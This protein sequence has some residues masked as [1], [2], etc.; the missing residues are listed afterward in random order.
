MDANI[1][2]QAVA[3]LLMKKDRSRLIAA[4]M[5]RLRCDLSIENAQLVNVLTG[6]IYPASVDVLDGVTVRVR[7]PDEAAAL[8]AAQ[9]ID[10]GGRY[11]LPGLIDS[12]MHVESSLLV[13]ENFGKAAVVWGTTMVVTDPHEIANVLGADG[14]RYMLDSARRSPVRQFALVPSCVPSLPGLETSGAVLTPEIIGA[15]LDEDGVIGLAEVMDYGAV[16]ADDPRMHGVLAAADARGCFIQGHAPR[17]MGQALCG[18]LVAGPVSDH[19]SKGAD[20]VLDKRRSGMYVDLRAH[21]RA[22]AAEV[23]AGLREGRFLDRVTLCTDDNHA[24]RLVREGHINRT[25][26]DMIDEGLDPLTA[27]RMV[28]YQAAQEY[29]FR[30]VGAVAP[31]FVADFQLRDDLRFRTKPTAVFIGGEQVVR[32]GRYLGEAAVR[33]SDHPG[34]TVRLPALSAEDFRIP[35]AGRA[36]RGVMVVNEGYAERTPVRER[37][38]AEDGF[39]AIPEERLGELNYIAVFNRYGTGTRTVAL[40]RGFGLKRGALASSIG[41]DCHNVCVVYAQPEDARIAVE[42]LRA[43]G[44]GV[45]YARD[46]EVRALL[47]LPVAG[48]MSDLPAEQTAA[49]CARVEQAIAED[50]G[51]PGFTIARLIFQPLPVFPKYTPTDLGV[52]DGPGRR[53][54]PVFDDEIFGEE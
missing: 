48:L 8:P 34:N 21:D 19:E 27:V 12:H 35:A 30:D 24:G 17:Q 38:A 3:G 11:L 45:C 54:V 37:L 42:A 20:E 29:G 52:V 10:A 18:Y 1:E 5:G 28:T 36:V 41:H 26:A 2:R 4:A 14:V 7:R 16:L 43:C 39:C 50:C 32:E 23:L 40:Y 33:A 13:P 53:F 49:E 22:Q 44:G 9:V 46:G 15:L 31:G 47:R 6:E 25:M 51:L